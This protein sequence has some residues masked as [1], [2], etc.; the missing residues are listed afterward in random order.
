MLLFNKTNNIHLILVPPPP[1]PRPKNA[2]WFRKKWV[3]FGVW[4]GYRWYLSIYLSN[5]I[6]Y[7][8]L[9]NL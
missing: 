2:S 8:T 6:K 9:I 3:I 1:R 4:T 5:T 7:Y